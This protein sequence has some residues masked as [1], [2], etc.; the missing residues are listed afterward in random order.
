MVVYKNFM[1]SYLHNVFKI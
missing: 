1:S